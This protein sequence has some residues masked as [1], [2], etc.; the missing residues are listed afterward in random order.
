MSFPLTDNALELMAAQRM[1]QYA[2]E[3]EVDHL[4]SEVQQGRRLHTFQ[5]L[6]ALAHG[7]AALRERVQTPKRSAARS[8][9]EPSTS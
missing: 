6:S 1:Q 7:L 9:R 2:H 3:A 4:V 5:S 8:V